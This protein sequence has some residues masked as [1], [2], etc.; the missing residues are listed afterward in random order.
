MSSNFD[1]PILG[2]NTADDAKEWYNN[3]PLT[4]DP[5]YMHF[6]D[7]F[8]RIA[9]DSGTDHRWTVVA[10][11][12]ASVAIEADTVGGR[13]NLASAAT[14]DGDG[15]SIQGNEIYAVEAGRY[16]HL[17]TLVEYHDADDCDFFF[18]LSENFST[19]PEAVLTASN[20]IGFQIT[21]GDASVLCI[22]ESGDA[23]TSTDSQEDAADATEMTL[24][25]RCIGTDIVEFYVNR[26]KVA[27]HT[28]NIP[29]ANMALAMA[30]ISGSATGTFILHC[31][32][33]WATMTR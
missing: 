9:F 10:D 27:T 18:G 21:E 7:D 12:G 5:D 30:H 14:T 3:L 1:P 8:D 13:V 25:I 2:V 28:T 11:T 17:E 33:I 6:M 32:Y 23:E 15:A 22:T 16:I 19:N 4:W 26:I 31:D 29:T 20:R 24:G